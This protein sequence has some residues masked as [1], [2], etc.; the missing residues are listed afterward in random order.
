[1]QYYIIVHGAMLCNAVCNIVV[2]ISPLNQVFILDDIALA[3]PNI[4]LNKYIKKL[5]NKILT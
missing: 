3:A 2:I 5:I 1:M 4:F